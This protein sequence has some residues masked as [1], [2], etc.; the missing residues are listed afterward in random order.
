MTDSRILNLR[1]NMADFK[2]QMS[3]NEMPEGTVY[4][5]LRRMKEERGETF[6]LNDY[7]FNPQ[8]AMVKEFFKLLRDGKSDNLPNLFFGYTT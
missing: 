2:K 8:M 7:G 3:C 1:K 4:A 6:N 5:A